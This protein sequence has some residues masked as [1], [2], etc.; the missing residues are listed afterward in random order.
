MDKKMED[1]LAFFDGLAPAQGSG[2]VH[3]P[4][5]RLAATRER[6]LREGI[7]VTEE[8]WKKITDAAQK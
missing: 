5:E 6:N 3:A 2:G 1:T 7:P 8:T 4:G